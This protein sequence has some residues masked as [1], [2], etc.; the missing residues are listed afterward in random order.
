M[1]YE[2]APPD[3]LLYRATDYLAHAGA[4]VLALLVIFH[5]F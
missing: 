3:G 5:P 4:V 2:Y 1:D